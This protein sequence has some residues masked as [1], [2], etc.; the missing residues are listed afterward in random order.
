MRRN[1]AKWIS[2]SQYENI[3]IIFIG[4]SV[5]L[6]LYF[7]VYRWL[8]S[9]FAI[10]CAIDRDDFSRKSFQ[11]SLRLT[12]NQWMRIFGNLLGI[13]L[14]IGLISSIFN[15]L[16]S[17]GGSS[18]GSNLLAMQN[19][20]MPNIQAML[21]EFSSIGIGSILSNILSGIIGLFSM[22]FTYILFKRLE[23]GAWEKN[24]IEP[25]TKISADTFEL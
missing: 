7:I 21:S 11:S 16:F 25:V 12:D 23:M 2:F 14:L 20:D 19:G 8:R 17:L 15:G 18:L 22:T 9:T 13:W 4:L 10:Y 3:G 6:T 24:I 1:V 5:I